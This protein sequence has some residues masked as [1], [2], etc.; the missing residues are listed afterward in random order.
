[1]LLCWSSVVWTLSRKAH[2][3]PQPVTMRQMVVVCGLLWLWPNC[4]TLFT[5]GGACSCVFTCACFCTPVHANC[6]RKR[7]KRRKGKFLTLREDTFKWFDSFY[8]TWNKKKKIC[9]DSFHQTF[10][11]VNVLRLA[12]MSSNLISMQQS[13][14]Q[15]HFKRAD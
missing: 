7:K 4:T 5:A 1:M 15:R 6:H 2:W 3:L 10:E 12:G 14:L 11:K 13:R 8:L 9:F